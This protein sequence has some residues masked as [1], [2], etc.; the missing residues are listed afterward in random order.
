MMAKKKSGAERLLRQMAFY[1]AGDIAEEIC[2]EMAKREPRELRPGEPTAYHEA[3]HG[4]IGL[5]FGFQVEELRLLDHPRIDGIC[6]SKPFDETVDLDSPVPDST[7]VN[8]LFVSLHIC[9]YLVSIARLKR[10]LHRLLKNHWRK[11]E[12]VAESLLKSEHKYVDQMQIL[13]TLEA[14]EKASPEDGLYSVAA[15]PRA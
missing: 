13:K 3:G 2:A 1:L 15:S 4:C 14:V 7:H 8:Q 12:A 10:V 5:C 11:I 9:G 6:L